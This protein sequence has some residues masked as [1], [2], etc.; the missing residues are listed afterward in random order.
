MINLPAGAVRNDIE[1]GMR[2]H[3]VAEAQLMGRYSRKRVNV[4][5]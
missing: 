4:R 2:S 1:S 5:D 3:I